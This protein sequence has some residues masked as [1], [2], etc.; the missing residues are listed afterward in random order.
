MVTRENRK[1]LV[2]K[3][4]KFLEA[5]SLDYQWVSPTI[6]EY[7]GYYHWHIINLRQE[8]SLASIKSSIRTN[9]NHLC[10]S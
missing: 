3:I 9:S 8:T 6:V 7:E 10:I 5:N 1:E 4:S 2:D